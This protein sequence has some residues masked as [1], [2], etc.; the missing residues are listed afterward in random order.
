MGSTVGGKKS[1]LV[2]EGKQNK[3]EGK[4]TACR[5]GFHDKH[6]NISII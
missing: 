5:Y 6:V 4:P 2:E 1:L 3:D